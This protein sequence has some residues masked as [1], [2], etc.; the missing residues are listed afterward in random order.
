MPRVTAPEDWLARLQSA[1]GFGALG[2]Y[3]WFHLWQQWPVLDGPDAWAERARATSR[4]WGLG[5]VAIV[6]V[7]HGALGWRRYLLRGRRAD[8]AAP[9]ADGL[10]RLQV[11]TGMVVLAFAAYHVVHVGAGMS[12]PHAS[13]RDAYR[14]LRASLG[15][16]VEL[17]IYLVGI[18]CACF[19]FAHGLVR[20]A[21]SWGLV[22]DARALRRARWVAGA[23]G[24]VLWGATLHV[25]GHFA[26]G[27]GLW[28]APTRAVAHL[29]A[30]MAVGR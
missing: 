8:P 17:V 23:L 18:S 6:L 29:V 2:A 3:L 21:M 27:E 26:I 10:R 22:R 14:A 13:A 28:S 7:V 16:P 25:L 20:A 24:F 11:V 15:Q 12:G 9:G 4:P 30:P 1:L 5:L 19:H